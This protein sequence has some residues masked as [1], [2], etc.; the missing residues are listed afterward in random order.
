MKKNNFLIVVFVVSLVG[1]VMWSCS[2]DEIELGQHNKYKYSV[3][4]IVQI[5][6]LIEK[7]GIDINI[8]YESKE[9]SLLSI[10]ELNKL[11]Q[12]ISNF[13]TTLRNIKTVKSTSKSKV[14]FCI[15]NRNLLRLMKRGGDFYSGQYSGKDSNSYG[16]AFFCFTWTGFEIERSS[17]DDISLSSTYIP[18]DDKYRID[19]NRYDCSKDGGTISYEIEYLV[20]VTNVSEDGSKFESLIGTFTVTGDF[21]IIDNSTED[22]NN[23]EN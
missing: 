3:E 6:S 23:N 9:G 22:S 21:S 15:G 1:M 8:L 14:E 11:F 12:C 5:E 19:M 17:A 10:E 7:Y 2:Q 4:E 18:S 13:Q 16:K 20:Y